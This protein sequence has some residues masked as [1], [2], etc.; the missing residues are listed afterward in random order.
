[1][2]LGDVKQTYANIDKSQEM[3]DYKPKISLKIGLEKF[4]KWYKEEGKNY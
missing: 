3:L 1:M 2:Q 4:I